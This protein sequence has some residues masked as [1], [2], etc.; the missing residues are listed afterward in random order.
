MRVLL[1]A[2][3]VLA[4]AFAAAP[5]A[6]ADGLPVLN[7]DVGA[8]GVAAPGGSVRYLTVTVGNKTLVEAT[9]RGGGQI[10]RMST[11]PGVWT[12]PAVAY[13]GSA[14]GLSADRS[15]L[16]LIEP[17]TSFP[18]AQ[19]RLLVVQAHKL[20]SATVIV[21]RGDF[22][23]D[24][25]SPSGS[26]IFL[27]HYT[28]PI[29]PTHYEVRAF[30][31]RTR[32]L[33]AKPIVDPRDATEK[34]RGNP[35]SRVMSP[36]GRIA[37]TLYD[38]GGHPFVHALDTAASTARCIDLEGIPPTTNLWSVRL[39]LSGGGRILT[40]DQGSMRLVSLDTR[41]W[42]PPVSASG[43]RWWPIALGAA[44]ALALASA[45]AVVLRLPRAPLPAP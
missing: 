7:V 27:I 24:A 8:S 16:V 34:M 13:D 41:T 35:M 17:R 18:R 45:A 38:G 6:S 33:L 42:Q 30:D 28:S 10:V 11:W 36:D 37:Y 5:A 20:T 1:A 21:L 43:L 26:R 4:L 39:H 29:D 14:S 12:I 9:S 32:R 2:A 25:V 31:V 19:T 40:A 44:L 22:S 15:T 3:A 23:F